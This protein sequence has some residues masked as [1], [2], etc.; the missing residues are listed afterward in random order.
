MVR[1]SKDP[2][3]NSSGLTAAEKCWRPWGAGR[4]RLRVFLAGRNARRDEPVPPQADRGS[5]RRPEYDIWVHNFALGTNTRITSDPAS[6][7]FATWSPD[8]NHI[9]FSSERGSSVF[10][11]YQK[12]SSGA[13]NDTLLFKSNEDKSAQDWSRDGK[14]LL[15]SV[16]N[17]GRQQHTN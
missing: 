13:G 5:S 2:S 15:Y 14:F 16:P 3:H 10:N 8:S 11:L 1:N 7:W 4:I 17:N 12:A 9:I 6:D